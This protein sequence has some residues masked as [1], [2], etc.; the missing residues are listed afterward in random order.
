MGAI[1]GMVLKGAIC[2][3]VL[4]GAICGKVLKGVICGNTTLMLLRKLVISNS[5]FAPGLVPLNVGIHTF[6]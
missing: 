6:N 4:K 1:C 3:K 5:H 2:G